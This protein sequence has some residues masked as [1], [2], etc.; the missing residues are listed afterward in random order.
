MCVSKVMLLL[1]S[2]NL[3][4]CAL[5]KSI[6]IHFWPMSPTLW[7]DFEFGLCPAEVEPSLRA[8]HKISIVNKRFAL[9]YDGPKSSV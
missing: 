5:K 6:Q 2:D 7:F 1:T 4:P 3:Y 9:P 8:R